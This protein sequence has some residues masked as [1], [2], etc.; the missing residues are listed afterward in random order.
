M[1]IACNQ[2][3]FAL[4]KTIQWSQKDT[5]GKEKVVVM[6]GG[7]HVEQVAIKASGTWLAGSGWVEV[8]PLQ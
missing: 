5:S 6:L 8:L 1:A 2:P 4:A 7:L 3:L